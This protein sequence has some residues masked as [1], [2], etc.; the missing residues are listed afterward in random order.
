M[1][2]PGISIT[3]ALL[4]LDCRF[5]APVGCPAETDAA[6]ED[7]EEEEEEEEEEVEDSV[8]GLASDFWSLDVLASRD[9]VSVLPLAALRSCSMPRP[10]EIAPSGEDLAKPAAS[11]LGDPNCWLPRFAEWWVSMSLTRDFC[12]SS[13]LASAAA[14]FVSLS[15]GCFLS[16]STAKLSAAPLAP[17]IPEP[18]EALP[19]L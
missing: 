18:L 2:F 19:S 1:R 8:V 10:G 7:K 12:C 9:E 4:V 16:I 5:A 13:S 14:S 17:P 6:S 11:E 15:P 3:P